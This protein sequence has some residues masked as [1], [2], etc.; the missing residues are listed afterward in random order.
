M[1]FHPRQTISTRRRTV[2]TASLFVWI[3][4]EMRIITTMMMVRKTGSSHGRQNIG[5]LK[6]RPMIATT[7]A[8]LPLQLRPRD[9]QYRLRRFISQ[10]GTEEGCSRR[11]SYMYPTIITPKHRYGPMTA[12]PSQRYSS[13]SSSTGSSS[14]STSSTASIQRIDDIVTEATNM[15][16]SICGDDLSVKACSNFGRIKYYNTDI[17]SRFRVLFV[18][19]GPGKSTR[20]GAIFRFILSRKYSLTNISILSLVRLAGS[21]KGTQS[22]LMEKN[23]PVAH[24]SVGELLRN[25]PDDSPHKATIDA[26]LVAGQIVPVEISLSLLRTAM[27]ATSSKHTIFLVDG[28]P[29]NYDNLMGWCR[30]MSQVA[31]LESILVYQ[32]PFPV[33]QERILERAKISGRSDDNIESVKK[34]FKTF[35]SETVP[36]VEI[37]RSV[38]GNCPPDRQRWSVVDISGDRSLDDV[39]VSTQQI[40]NQVIQSDVLTANAALLTAIQLR[41]VQAYEQLCDPL[42]FKDK[43]VIAVMQQHEG[44]GDQVSE[45]QSAKVEIITGRQVTVS[46]DR[47]IDDVVIQE[48]RFWSHQGIAGWR[49]VHFVRTPKQTTCV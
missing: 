24:F 27:E 7:W 40:L 8:W 3:F 31:V 45:V 37:L 20:C 4:V 49:N 10:I 26:K 30:V 11:Y 13:S 28:F 6:P 29:R 1:I 48:K 23:Y 42:F 17:D 47:L 32:C 25:V 43:D 12:K 44:R 9:D 39:W 2:V 15:A 34:R 35:E 21:G 19:G 16:N 41:D 46:Y 38:S 33:L 22:A 5:Q 14:D 36:V 18:L